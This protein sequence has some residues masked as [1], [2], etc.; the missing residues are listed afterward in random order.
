MD[1]EEFYEED[2]RRQVS[3]EIDFGHEWSERGSR[4]EVAWIA[5]TGEVYAMA[6]PSVRKV[7]TDMVTVEV[8]AVVEGRDNITAALSGWQDAMATPD[9][10]GWVRARVAA[11][12]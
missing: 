8:L 11:A 6:E 1:I 10:L 2:P 12:A 9:S 7:T 5:D 3:A 4:F